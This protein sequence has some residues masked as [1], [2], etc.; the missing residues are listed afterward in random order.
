MK[1]K[2]LTEKKSDRALLSGV[3]PWLFFIL[4]LGLSW[5]FW[6]PMIFIPGE[7]MSF[8][9]I[10]LT[11]LGG[12]GPAAAEFVLIFFHGEESLRRDYFLR[13][14][15]FRRI[16]WTWAVGILVLFPLL[17]AAA[18]GLSVLSGGPEPTWDTVREFLNRPLSLIPYLI[19]M[20]LFGPLPEELGWSGYAL[21]GLQQKRSALTSSLIIGAVWAVWHLPLFF[22]EGTFQH[23]QIGF[24]T[25][26]FWWF[27]L[28]TLPI[29][30]LDTW[31]Y[32]NNG[33]STLAAVL[34][35]FMV[36][37][38]GELFN[39][40]SRARFFQLVLLLLFTAFVV[41]YWGPDQLTGA[42]SDRPG[43]ALVPG[44][45]VTG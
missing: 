18:T 12:L 7:P 40:S 30:I 10:L 33:R 9:L 3:N 25:P 34:L 20:F 6:I 37:L 19:V 35:H 15:D 1:Y 45:E 38:S 21:D 11:I 23:D 24:A 31:M 5:T 32:N 22:V 42:K 2:L 28:P 27:M 39:L 14:F 13:I 26:A 29:S 36:N 4:A 16:R 43:R 8:P 41:I 17:N 44:A